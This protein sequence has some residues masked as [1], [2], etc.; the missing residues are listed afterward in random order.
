MRIQID[1]LTTTQIPD[2]CQRFEGCHENRKQRGA[3]APTGPEH[4][5]T[6][7]WFDTGTPQFVDAE[8]QAAVS[9]PVRVV[10][11]FVGL[12]CVA[13]GLLG[14]VLPGL[15]TTPFL[16]LASWCFS[17][18]SKRLEQ[19]L[20][21]SRLFGPLIQDWRRHRA[22]HRHVRRFAVAFVV[23]TT[24]ATCG[25]SSLGF[26]T[27][28]VVFA[29]ACVGL[30]V[31]LRLPVLPP[32]RQGRLSANRRTRDEGH[33]AAAQAFNNVIVVRPSC[34]ESK[35]DESGIFAS[36]SDCMLLPTALRHQADES[37]VTQHSSTDT[38]PVG[39]LNVQHCPS[40]V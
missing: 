26:I 16:L 30:C 10:A 19:A 31:I 37:Q 29:L 33:T 12:L 25:F 8:G 21:T 24:I 15:P 14:I 27:R 20:L 4:I 34:R 2:R 3:A 1:P 5:R 36:H 38:K 18:C 6:I 35:S 17:R 28:S 23:T 13:L 11:L 40:D 22:V 7:R 9:Y 39:L 32:G